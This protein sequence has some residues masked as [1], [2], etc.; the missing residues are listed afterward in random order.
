[1]IEQALSSER[2]I[3]SALDWLK[4]EL[5]VEDIHTIDLNEVAAKVFPTNMRDGLHMV[6]TTKQ[7]VFNRVV[8]EVLR[9]HPMPQM[10]EVQ[11]RGADARMTQQKHRR[12]KECRRAARKMMAQVFMSGDSR[13]PSEIPIQEVKVRSVIVKPV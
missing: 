12:A 3:I 5:S 6:R 13:D 1:M 8:T 10:P 11:F 7:A 9:A 2:I 4:A